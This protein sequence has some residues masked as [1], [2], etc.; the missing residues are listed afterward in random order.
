MFLK[1]IQLNFF[2]K[3]LVQLNKL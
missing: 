1:L 3:R 2:D